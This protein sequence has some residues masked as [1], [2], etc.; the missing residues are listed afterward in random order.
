[1]AREQRVARSNGRDGSD[2]PASGT[3]HPRWDR[4]R[5]TPKDPGTAKLVERAH[6]RYSASE[7]GE[8]R[9]KRK[10]GPAGRN[11]P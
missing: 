8:A 7:Q 6:G 3:M 5:G 2:K 4:K 9:R 10:S 1:M 11:V